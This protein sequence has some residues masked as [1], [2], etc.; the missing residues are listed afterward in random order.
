MINLKIFVDDSN[1]TRGANLLSIRVKRTTHVLRKVVA[2]GDDLA[3]YVSRGR[4]DQLRSHLALYDIDAVVS[5]IAGPA[6][7]CVEIDGDLF[8]DDVQEAVDRWRA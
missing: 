7:D 1:E 2:L 4:G 5:P 3:V 8:P 6:F